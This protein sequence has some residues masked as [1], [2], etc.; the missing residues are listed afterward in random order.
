MSNDNSD[1]DTADPTDGGGG[2]STVLRSRSAATRRK[3]LATNAAV[4]TSAVV[5]GCSSQGQQEDET[6]EAP[7]TTETPEPTK[8]YVLSEDLIAGSEG[9][10]KDA[11]LVSACAPTRTFM[12]GMHAVF[13][14]GVY[15]PETGESV[16]NDTID[17]VT[18]KMDNGVTVDLTWAGDDEEHPHPYW[19]GSW[20]IPEDA[21]PGTIKYSVELTGENIEYQNVEV[22]ADE[23][24]II[25]D[26]HPKNYVVTDELVASGAVP[27]GGLVSSC[28]TSRTFVPGMT[29]VFDVGV[30]DPATGEPVSNETI[31]E[32]VVEMDNGVTVE[33]Q[34]A[35]DDEEHPAPIWGGSWDVPE[36]AE[37]TDVTYTIN[38]TD[39][40]NNYRDVNVEENTFSIVTLE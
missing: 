10:P 6:T 32:M 38:I 14:V 36:D 26:F 5:A 40:E 35:G 9:L 20:T 11:G 18:V 16:G 1:R 3:F 13:K 2:T 28:G 27:E 25:D 30:Y 4:W 19:N 12:P 8:N 31:D 21:D 22:A 37:P 7:T 29:V 17:G 15:D 34:W 23:F 24:S 33:L 39:E